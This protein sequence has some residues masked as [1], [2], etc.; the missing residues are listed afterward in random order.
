MSQQPGVAYK[1]APKNPEEGITTCDSGREHLVRF[2]CPSQSLKESPKRSVLFPFERKCVSPCQY[3][4]RQFRSSRAP[5]I[6]GA[7]VTR[8]SGNVGETNLNSSTLLQSA[9]V[10][11]NLNFLG[12]FENCSFDLLNYTSQWTSCFCHLGH[13]FYLW[14]ATA[15]PRR[16]RL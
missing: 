2:E 12:C 10:E 13:D 8:S 1:D 14:L 15:M 16:L 4:S 6:W 11:T 7:K 3:L 5:V 9:K